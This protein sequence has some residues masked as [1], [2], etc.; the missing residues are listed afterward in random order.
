MAD[1]PSSDRLSGSEIAIVG[2]SCRFPGASDIEQ[3]WRNLCGGV[4]SLTDLSDED[5]RRAAVDPGLAG[6]P[7]Y[8]RRAAVLDGIELFDPAFFGYTPLEAKLMDPQHRLFLECAWEVFE[9][10]GYDPETYPAPIG[11]FTGAKTDT[12]LLNLVSNRELFRTLDNFQIALGND[13]AAMATRVSYKLNLRGPSYALHTA[14][15][16]SLVTVHLACQSLLLDE[17]RMAVAGGAAINVPQRK[18]YLY[19][20]GGILSPDGT[21]RTFDAGAQGSNFGN[22]AGAVLLKRL[23]DARADGDH[24]WAV[25]RGSATNNDG[26]RKASYTAPGVEGQTAVLLEAIACAGVEPRDISYVEA[27]GTAT[28]LGDSIEVLALTEAFR[29][30]TAERRFC[31]LGSVKTNIGHLETAA[32]IAGLIKTALALDRRQIPP[33]LHFQTPNPKIDFAS[34]PFYVN[35]ALAEWRSDGRP[36]R[37]GVSSFGIGSTNAH[38]ILEEA[39]AP[40]ATTPAV[41]PRQLLILSARSESALDAMTANLARHL[42]ANAGLDLADVAYTLQVGRKAFQHRRAVIGAGDAAAA[43]GALCEADGAR[44]MTG[45][46]GTA[47][48]SVVFLFPGLGDHAVDMGLGLYQ[49]EPAFRDALDRCAEL[50]RPELGTDLRDL[51]FPRGAGAAERVDADGKADL[52]RLFG[53]PASEADAPAARRLQETRFAQPATFAVEYALACLWLEWGIRPQAMIGYSLGEYVAA[54][55]SGVLSLA[56]A[57]K[58]VARRA[59]G[60]QGLPAGSMTA[61]PLAEAELAPR[62]ARHG[63]S[64]AALNGPAI[65][66]ASGPEAGIAALERELQGEGIVCRRLPT[67]HAFH[68]AMME[69]LAGDLTELARTVE[70]RAP[71]IPYLSNVTGT[72]ITAAEAA[73]PSYWARHMCGPVRFGDGLGALLRPEEGT[74]RIFLEVGPG[75]SLGSFT[76]LHPGCGLERGRRVVASMRPAHGGPPSLE[77]LLAALGQLWALGAPVD[78]RAFHAGERRRR[79][80][81]PTYPFERQAYWVDPDGIAPP[82]P[83]AAPAR[84]VTLD[85]QGDIADWFYHPLWRPTASAA[86]AAPPPAGC[87]LLFADDCGL[88]GRLAERLRAGGGEVVLATPGE[89]FAVTGSG[90]FVLRPAHPEDYS[91]LL[92]ELARRGRPPAGIVHLWGAGPVAADPEEAFR[93][94]Q[95]LGFY[96]L[97]FLAQA[98]GRLGVREPLRIDVVTSGAHSVSGRETLVP[99]RA[100]VLGPC[101]VI[102]QEMARVTCRN[103]DLDWPADREAAADL[104]A[105]EI[106]S[107]PTADEIVA[108]RGG[109]RWVQEL[110]AVRLEAESA[111]PSRLRERGVYLLTGGLGGLGLAV[112]GYLVR[113]VK[114]RLIL[115]GRRAFPDRAGWEDWLA[116]HGADDGVSVR[117]RA[118]QALEAQGAEV[119]AAGVDAGDETAVRAL[120]AA[121]R[122]RFGRIDGVF[123]LAGT[124]GGGIIQLK[125]REAAERIMAPKVRGARVLDAVFGGEDVDFLL[126][127]SSLASVLGELGQADYCG[128]NAFLD[129]VALRN[130]ARGGPPTLTINWDI[131]REVG[132]AVYTEVPAHLRAWRQEMLDKAILTSEG[133]EALDRI[134]HADLA[135]V[136]VSAQP[137]HGRIELGKSFTGESFLAEL[138]KMRAPQAAPRP[139]AV[140]AAPGGNAERRI[141]EIWRRVLGAEQ[142]GLQ[143]NFFDL[144]GNS[145][146][147]LQVVSEIGRE[148]GTEIPPVTL[149]EAPTVSA[150]ARH[151]AAVGEAPAAVARARPAQGAAIAVIGMA[152]RFPGARDVEELWRNLCDGVESVTF[153]S[154]EELLAAGVDRELLADPRYVRAGAVLEGIDRFDAPLFGY[155]PREAEVMDPQHRIF[156]ECAWEL[157]E[158]AGWNTE[159]YPGRVGVFAGSNLSTYLLRLYADPEVRRSVNMLQAILGNDKDSLTS[160]VSY[161]LNLRG[162]SVAVQTFCSTSLVAVHLA[163]QSLRAGE[164]DMA[165]A[166][167]IRVVVPDRQGYLYERGGLSPADGHSRSFDAKANGS[168][169][170]NGVGAVLLKRLDD[171]LADGD[172][173]HAVI[174]GSAIN[175]DGSVKA[176]YTA[177]SVGGQVEAIAAA[178]ADAGVDPARLGYV[179]AHGSATELGDPIELAALTKALRRFT[180]GQRFCPIGSVK[181]NFGHLDRAAGVTGLIKTVLALE[182]GVLPPSINFAEPNPEIDFDNSPFFVN[183]ELREWKADGEPRL[184]A[185]NSLGIGGTNAHVVLEEA[186]PVAPTGPSRPWQLLI[187]SANSPEALER[188]AQNLAEHCERHP[189]LSFADAAYTLQVGRR[190]LEHRRMAVCRDLAD[191]ASVLRGGDPRRVFTAC[192]EEGE[193]PVVF[194]FSGLGGQYVDMGRGLYESEPTFRAEV[195]RCAGALEPLLGIDLRQVMVP[196][197]SG[198]TANAAGVDLRR[199]LGRETRGEA[200]RRLDETRFAQP[201]LFVLE[202]ALARQW[203]EWG[204]RPAAVAGYSVGEY[205]AACLAGVLSLA[206]ALTLVAERARL[207]QGLPDGAMLAVGLAEEALGPLLG[208]ELSLAAVNGPEQS[209]VGGPVPAVEELERRLA[210]DGIACRRLPVTHAF[211]SRMMEPA[212]DALVEQARRLDLRPPSLPLLS[213]LTG[214]WLTADEA[215]DPTYWARHMCGTVRF[216]ESIA[217]LLRDPRRVLLELGPG[218]TLAS[219]VL[220]H[221][222]ARPQAGREPVVLPTVRHSYETVADVAYALTTLGKLWL[223]GVTIDW[224]GFHAQAR[225]LRVLLP[226]YPFERRRYWIDTRNDAAA[227]GR[228]R[229]EGELGAYLYTRSWKRSALPEPEPAAGG[230]RSWLVLADGRGVGD[231]I[232]AALRARGDGVAVVRSGE[233]PESWPS[234]LSALGDPPDRVLHLWSLDGAEDFAGLLELAQQLGGDPVRLWVVTDGLLEVNGDEAAGPRPAVLLGA[235][236]VIAERLPHIDCRAIDAIAPAPGSAQPE[237]LAGQLLAELSAAPP[238]RL[239]AYRGNHRWVQVLDEVPADARVFPP[240]EG[241]VYLLAGGLEEPGYSFARHLTEAGSAVRLILL[242]PAGFPAREEW[243]EWLRASAGGLIGRR[244]ARARELE[245]N[246]AELAVAAVDLADAEAVRRAVAAEEARWGELQGLV[247]VFAPAGAGGAGGPPAERLRAM[248]ALDALRRGRRLGFALLVAPEAVRGTAADAAVPFALDALASTSGAGWTSVAWGLGTDCR[249]GEAVGRLL[250][251]G[252]A[253]QVV[254]SPLPLPPAWSGLEGLPQGERSAAREGVGFYPRPRLRVELVAPRNAT[255]EQIAAIWRDLLGVAQVGVHDNFLDLGGDSLLA[256]RLVARMR[257]AFQLDLPMRLLFERSTVAELAVAVDEARSQCQPEDDAR[258]LKEVRELSEEELEAEISRLESLLTVEEESHG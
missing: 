164:C 258:L 237:R 123:H 24:V 121:A 111:P 117:I 131:W 234:L 162:P 82:A 71:Q 194:L 119:M 224:A 140:A 135:R 64:L 160:T 228:R 152:G 110:A 32:G 66:V 172:H 55:L 28:D 122:R 256:T 186:P 199:M 215:V 144:G 187:L 174:R 206:D 7:G 86:T 238:E 151:L 20:K 198:S 58:L 143:D 67:T 252:P 91:A 166:G 213:N 3:F 19:Q 154:E 27:H 72:W 43:A 40:A 227:I 239:A 97:L 255:E 219:L 129:A 211:H 81:L 98:L 257:D 65:S 50:L 79:V 26:A 112:A 246:G 29:A 179:E 78:W 136:I 176:G 242:E 155:S 165:V 31:A 180:D 113:R 177:P 14:C 35:T 12:Y 163:C 185:V 247:A 189:E 231:R 240:R 34:S 222:A 120:V 205:T 233:T 106:A 33:S 244:L 101:K 197:D 204:I 60:I 158:R 221:P 127:F 96:S 191:A 159:T 138:E 59:L 193:P 183:T 212:F 102:P 90:G 203:M 13:L 76:R 241:G 5:L 25:I 30:G 52:R 124:P 57:L 253:R 16:T 251:A 92:A 10:A 118:V 100:T 107:P 83:A 68:S 248:L 225:R 214:R 202:Y 11:V 182:H 128:A 130:A 103:I 53:R 230:R 235:C 196:P 44:W 99:E 232:A 41:R 250:A 156:L 62:L 209:V 15:S 229:P 148:L 150:L 70:H 61:V 22:G 195:D 108:L 2:M 69:P 157:F 192:R 75:Q 207:I 73:D 51:L 125:T 208:A 167:G 38:V 147:A 178:F 85:K 200:S 45:D 47:E 39:P 18:G 223:L 63:V 21:C 109:E 243:E 149:F 210:A 139:A 42:E 132:L 17:C 170:G 218:P 161:K 115:T 84:R 49:T 146:L 46:R 254:A 23:A 36:R 37:A 168:I 105:A 8:V 93:R 169:L 9:Q 54:C 249:G 1:D 216:A 226:A 217:E 77:V 171:A 74:E 190:G 201:A 114:A 6:H 89:A 153:F 141:A 94:T 181:A 126:L 245:A 173:I 184:A 236:R 133:V 87:W 95:E 88:A 134:L 4:E 137:L 188:A 80:P 116:S 220:Q 104:L 56:D 175:N 145:L 48:R 142:I